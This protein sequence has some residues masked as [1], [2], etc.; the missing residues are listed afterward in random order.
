VRVP[1]HSASK[2]VRRGAAPRWSARCA[3]PPPLRLPVA[4][5]LPSQER[6]PRTALWS[7]P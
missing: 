1:V 4:A 2:L 6:E 3:D 7:A 5:E